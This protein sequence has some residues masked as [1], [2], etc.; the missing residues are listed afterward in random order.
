MEKLIIQVL[1]TGRGGGSCKAPEV[2]CWCQR[3]QCPSEIPAGFGDIESLLPNTRV[4]PSYCCVGILA[5]LLLGLMK[6]MGLP[7]AEELR[8]G[9]GKQEFHTVSCRNG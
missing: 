6:G 7:I 4:S 5:K 9:E 1:L 2:C 3:A 8:M